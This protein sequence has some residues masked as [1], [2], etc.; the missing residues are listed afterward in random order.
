MARIPSKIGSQTLDFLF[1]SKYPSPGLHCKC[2]FAP[3]HC[4]PGSCTLRLSV[5]PVL[6]LGL[7]RQQKT[8]C[9][10]TGWKWLT[11]EESLRYVP[12]SM[13]GLSYSSVGGWLRRK[14]C[15][16]FLWIKVKTIPSQPI[17]SHL[18]RFLFMSYLTRDKN[19]PFRTS[20]EDIW[21]ISLDF[22][23]LY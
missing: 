19:Y 6:I 1:L 21:A 9:V 3:G 2:A 11:F 4:A 22:P 13:S 10:P 8:V 23:K 5:L 17:G 16:V 14:K 15:G 18:P 12:V 20:V 7:R